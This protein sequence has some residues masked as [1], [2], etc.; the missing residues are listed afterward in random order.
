VSAILRAGRDDDAASFIRIISDCWAEY[1]GCVTD[2]DGEAPELHA[3]ASYCA[4]RGGAV[5]AAQG[6]GDVV[7]MVCTYPLADGAWEL[8]KMYVARDHR[9]GGI[10]RELV[11]AAENFA[12][13]HG[14]TRMKLWS[15]TRF[16]RAHRF[17]EKHDFVRAGPLRVL[18]DKSNSI[19]FGYAKPLAGAAVERLDAAGAASA[20][21]SLARILVACVDGGAAVSFL[22][23]LA[24]DRAR[25]FWRGVAGGVAR[26]EKILLAAWL[27][28]AM[29]GTVQLDLTTPQN[30]P[31]RADLA[32]M[33]VH[34]QARRR[35]IGRKMLAR[36]GAE[37]AVAERSLL[38]LDTR[39]GD[40]A[41]ALY[42][43]AGWIEC[44]RIPGYALNA[45]RTTTHATVLFYRAVG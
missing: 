8:G 15:D 17:Y 3:L 34:P 1:P 32:K 40:L 14:G 44:G 23:P 33:L 21:L 30:Q 38:V 42:R 27:D 10:A 13:A 19:E 41:E 18:A 29:V 36:A 26:G 20:E 4:G 6:D 45:D 22:P 5:W 37:A 35:G 25:A 39:E 28:G 16:D 31:H 7:G 9:G 11:H 12:R 43:S 2:I 24:L